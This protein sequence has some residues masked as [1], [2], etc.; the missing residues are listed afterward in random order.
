MPLP[1][2]EPPTIA[3]FFQD[4]GETLHEAFMLIEALPGVD[5][6]VVEMMVYL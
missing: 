2:T 1:L 3:G 5:S 6:I 4:A